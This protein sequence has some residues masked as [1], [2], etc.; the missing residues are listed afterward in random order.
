[1][2]VCVCV[3]LA[4]LSFVLGGVVGGMS[5]IVPTKAVGV[6]GAGFW[7]FCKAKIIHHSG[8]ADIKHRAREQEGSAIVKCGGVDG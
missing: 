1:M 4:W 7:H 6:S 2:Y 5:V 3:L 8:I